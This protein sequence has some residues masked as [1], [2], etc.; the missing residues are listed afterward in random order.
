MISPARFEVVRE[1]R[2]TQRNL[3]KTI[4]CR[5]TRPSLVEDHVACLLTDGLFERAA[6]PARAALATFTKNPL[7][8]GLFICTNATDSVKS[9]PKSHRS[10]SILRSTRDGERIVFFRRVQSDR[11]IREGFK[12][13]KKMTTP[14]KE[15][16]Y[17]R[18][19]RSESAPCAFLVGVNQSR[20]C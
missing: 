10:H 20:L 4:S 9:L 1:R 8:L 2:E 7:R 17:R 15:E 19:I 14:P 3:L 16:S 5:T 13:S 11:R 18:R 12:P 6:I